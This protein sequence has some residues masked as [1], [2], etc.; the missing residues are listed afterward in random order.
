MSESE[1]HAEQVEPAETADNP[2]EPTPDYGEKDEVAQ[3]QEWEEDV[4]EGGG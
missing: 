2:I 4:R 3:K 1:E